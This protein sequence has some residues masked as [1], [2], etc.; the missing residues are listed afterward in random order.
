MLQ[1]LRRSARAGAPVL[2][3]I[4]EQQADRHAGRTAVVFGSMDV[5]YAEVDARANRIARRLR[6]GGVGPGS[7]VAVLLSSWTA[8]GSPHVI[9]VLTREGSASS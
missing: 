9:P 2:H 8:A 1:L 3:S 4:F 5:T 6:Y 7:F